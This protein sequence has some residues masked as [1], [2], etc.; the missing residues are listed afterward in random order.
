MPQHPTREAAASALL[1]C[2]PSVFPPVRRRGSGHVPWRDRFSRRGGRERLGTRTPPCSRA[3]PRLGA[4]CSVALLGSRWVCDAVGRHLR[5]PDLERAAPGWSRPW[6]KAASQADREL[7]SPARTYF[8]RKRWCWYP[9]CLQERAVLGGKVSCRSGPARG[10]NAGRPGKAGEQRHR[11]GC[12][13]QVPLD[14]AA[15]LG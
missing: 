13:S 8:S 5:E 11:V 3:Q 2:V 9:S 1:P 14:A 10:T 4:L 6:C 7:R 12:R 15:G